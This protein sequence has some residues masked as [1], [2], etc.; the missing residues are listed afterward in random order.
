M[1]GM[2]THLDCKHDIPACGGALYCTEVLL[3]V[4]QT[5][6]KWQGCGS[7]ALSHRLR[8]GAYSAV[9]LAV[10]WY[11]DRLMGTNRD[12]RSQLGTHKALRMSGSA[13]DTCQL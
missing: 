3:D 8:A 12:D 5:S 7:W 6:L 1:P 10:V 11:G 4:R 9:V 13:L 2:S